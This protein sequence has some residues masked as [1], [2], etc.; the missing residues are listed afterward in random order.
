MSRPR[1][2]TGDCIC[3]QCPMKLSR[4]LEKSDEQI[5]CGLATIQMTS[6]QRS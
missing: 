4:E 5:S 2:M 6:L 3:R 1:K